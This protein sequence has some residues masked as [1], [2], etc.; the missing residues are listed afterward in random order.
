[1]RAILL[2]AGQGQRLRPLTEDRPK[3]M[4]EV[5]GLPLLRWQ[6]HALRE[7]GIDDIVVV[8][9]WCRSRIA[10]PD[11]RTLDNPRW[12]STNMVES[13][14]CAIDEL[15]GD[16]LIAYTDLLYRPEVIQAARSSS[17]DVGVVV[18]L[19]WR[20]LWESRMED[21]VSDAETLRM[22]SHGR[23]LE[24]G[25]KPKNLDEIQAQYTGLIRLSPAGCEIFQRQLRRAVEADRAGENVFHSHRRLDAAYMTDLLMGL[26]HREVPV[27][28]VPIRGGWT[29]IDTPAD[30]GVADQLLSSPEWTSLR[31]LEGAQ[32]MRKPA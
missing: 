20:R 10:G 13:L 15:H 2:G 29:E 8:R 32:R 11:F 22:D 3:C 14:R 27:M 30:L 7:A 28:A 24:I 18:D 26:I 6:L 4:V 25:Q 23:I 9:G 1:M 16:V 5:G 17:A 31:E 12:D 19:D 21:P